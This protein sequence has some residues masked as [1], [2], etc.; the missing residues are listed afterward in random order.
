MSARGL[1]AEFASADALVAAVKRAR[2]EGY[3]RLDAYSPFPIEA[4]GPAIG[5]TDEPKMPWI[6]LAGAVF[7][8][9]IGFFI[10]VYANLF[11]PLNIGGRRLLS[12]PA[13]LVSTFEL[14]ILF[15]GFFLLFGMLYLNGMP[16]LYHP[17][18]EAEPFARAT[19]DRFFL[20]IRGDDP[21]VRS[22]DAEIFLKNLSPVSL[23]EVDA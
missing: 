14:M 10:Q 7:G 5:F 17:V 18:A 13:F 15:S 20:C 21:K 4:I 2:S 11:Y 19:R 8:A 3:S 12:I 6:G 23:T 16:K 1:L 22:G 9:F